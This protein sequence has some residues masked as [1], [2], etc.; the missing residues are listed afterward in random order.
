[1]ASVPVTTSIASARRLNVADRLASFARKMPDAIAVACP[2]R[3]SPHAPGNHIGLS[4]T[5][6]STVTF[7]EL[8]AEANRLA[9][10][11]VNWGV[12]AGAR[13]ALLVQPGIEF[14]TLVFALLRAGVVIVLIDPGIGRRNLVRSLADANPDGFVAIP[15]AQCVRMLMRHKFPRAKWQVTVGRRW[16]W[17]G[18]TVRQLA[19]R[20]EEARDITLPETH[21]DDPAAIILTSGSTGPAKGVLYSQRMFDTQVTEIR[22]AYSISA[23]GADLS[24]FP[25]FALFNSAMGV[26][27][28]L[29]EMDFSRPAAASPLRLLDAADDWQ[30]TQAFASP[31]VWKRLSRFCASQVSG[32]ARYGKS[33]RAGRQCRRR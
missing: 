12:P 30:V 11:L 5:K 27:T 16:G 32:S 2:K 7:A 20:G 9:R 22:S 23:G 3:A 10:G 1:M 17:G 4:G 28:V 6:Y 29:P 25:L 31:A 8:D 21:A 15:S 18:L 33:F 19:E 13:L 26:T 14:V 24:C